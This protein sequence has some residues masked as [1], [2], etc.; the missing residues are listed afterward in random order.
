M[1]SKNMRIGAN[2]APSN[3][4][5]SLSIITMRS[6]IGPWTWA[7]DQ[8]RGPEPWTRAVDRSRVQY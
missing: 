6:C 2:E 5:P 3:E 7:G 1:V 8:S 4:A